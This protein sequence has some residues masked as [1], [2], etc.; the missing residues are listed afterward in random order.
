MRH[1]LHGPRDDFHGVA[2]IPLVA[3]ELGVDI[4][5]QLAGGA[6]MLIAV[7]RLRRMLGA[8]E[9]CRAVELLPGVERLE[10]VHGA[11]QVVGVLVQRR[12]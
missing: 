8:V 1:E 5:D 7:Q 9:I 10:F 3:P 6:D 4:V 12:A 2:L 11:L